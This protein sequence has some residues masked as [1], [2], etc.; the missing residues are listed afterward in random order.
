MISHSENAKTISEIE[1]E[2]PSVEVFPNPAKDYV[3]ITFFSDG[4][5]TSTV[6]LI[7]INGRT[8]KTISQNF[9]DG[10]NEFNVDTQDLTSGIYFLKFT[11]SDSSEMKRLVIQK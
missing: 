1:Y 5:T 11:T 2:Q 7:D 4:E 9:N 3:K 6:Q 8:V 10:D